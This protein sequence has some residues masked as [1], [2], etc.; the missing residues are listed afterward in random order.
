MA[1][2]AFQNAP[3]WNAVFLMV[4][5]VA[6][7]HCQ[8]MK[9][10][11]LWP[12]NNVSK[13]YQLMSQMHLVFW[14][15]PIALFIHR[16]KNFQLL[17]HCL[18]FFF[19]IFT[20]IFKSFL[21]SIWYILLVLFQE[22]DI[23]VHFHMILEFMYEIFCYFEYLPSWPS[24]LRHQSSKQRPQISKCIEESQRR[25][26]LGSPESSYQPGGPAR[27]PSDVQSTARAHGLKSL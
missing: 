19:S 7:G 5:T 14:N 8:F 22:L 4:V 23:I 17:Q 21:S 2:G 15:S 20:L 6:S 27:G 10:Q 1:N 11:I 24:G 9:L 3:F 12:R 26:G 18:N 13:K 16:P 25:K